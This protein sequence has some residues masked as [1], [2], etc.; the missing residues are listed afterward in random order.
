MP[1]LKMPSNLNENEFTVHIKE[2]LLELLSSEEYADVTLFSDDQIT[3]KAHKFVLSAC[4][5]VFKEMIS[6]APSQSP[7]LYLKG[8]EQHELQSLLTFINTSICREV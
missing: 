2:M 5:P 4:S 1:I 8:V 7:L 6:K 3:F